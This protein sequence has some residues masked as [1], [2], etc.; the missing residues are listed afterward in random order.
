MGTRSGSIDP[1]IL[2][3]LAQRQ[4]IGPHKLDE[5]LFRRSGLF[6]LTG[7][8]DMREVLTRAGDGDAAA[9][10]GLDVYIQA[11]R[12][13]IAAMVTALRGFDALV[14]TGGVGQRSPD[15]RARAVEALSFLGVELDDAANREVGPDADISAPGARVRTIVVHAREDLEMAREVRRV[16][17]GL[18]DE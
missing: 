11:L 5:A 8:A 17:G 3:W 15:V 12:K 9:Q 18:E 4:G 7:T 6:A 13:G 2:L 1:G 14:F 16:V 10:L